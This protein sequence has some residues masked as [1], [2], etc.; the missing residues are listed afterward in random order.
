MKLKSMVTL[1]LLFVMS[2]SLIHEYVFA[3]YDDDHCSATEYVAE[4]EGPT[5]HGDICDI[6]YEYHS[7]YILPQSDAKFNPIQISYNQIS[8]NDSYLFKTYS[9]IIKPP[10]S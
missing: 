4:L 5:E 8:K 2:F 6:H 3:Y 9:K 7:T 1:A 10:I